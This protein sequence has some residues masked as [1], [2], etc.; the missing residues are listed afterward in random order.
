MLLYL[1]LS[2]Y[3]ALSENQSSSWVIQATKLNGNF[4]FYTILPDQMQALSSILFIIFIPLF[5][6][7]IYP[8]LSKIGLRRP[9]QKITSSC[10][11]AAV[12]ILMSAFVEW[13]IQIEPENSLSI[14]WQIPQILIITMGD[15]MFGVTC[16]AFS[17]EQSPKHLK[18][19]V[20]CLRLLIVGLGN[21]IIAIITKLNIFESQVYFLL[22]YVALMIIAMFIFIIMAYNYKSKRIEE[23][24]N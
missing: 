15:I 17:Y 18:S 12:A 11:L 16:L 6:Y 2:M 10:F 13:R 21:A 24:E 9:L 22:L 7:C 5:D 3:W 8:L 14:L 19:L 20:L 4:G 23:Q 1:P